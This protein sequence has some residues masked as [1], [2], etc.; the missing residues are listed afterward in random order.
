MDFDVVPPSTRWTGSFIRWLTP[1]AAVSFHLPPGGQGLSSE[2]PCGANNPGFHLSPGGQGAFILEQALD[3]VAAVP[4]ADHG[5]GDV[6][7]STQWTGSFIC[8]PLPW[9][10]PPFTQWT[11]SFTR[12]PYYLFHLSPSGQGSSPASSQL[13]GDPIHCPFTACHSQPA[14]S[15][16]T[17]L[18]ACWHSQRA[19]QPICQPAS[20]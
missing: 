6:P 9:R 3:V 17:H 5:V 11:G 1:T 10:V 4:S 16:P 20:L 7:P 14:V 18:P 13:F 19:S 12:D 8:H 15:Q 2:H